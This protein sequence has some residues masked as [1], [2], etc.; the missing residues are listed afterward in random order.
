MFKF[1][2]FLIL[3]LVCVFALSVTA[4][5]SSSGDEKPSENIRVLPTV[6]SDADL[7][8]ITS[9]T[10]E[11]MDYSVTEG[12]FIPS[13]P[14]ADNL[15]ILC[16]D[17]YFVLTCPGVASGIVLTTN[18]GKLYS[19]RNDKLA[20][21]SW[22]LNGSESGFVVTDTFG[23]S[24][25]P[26]WTNRGVLEEPFATDGV[27][28]LK[29]D[30]TGYDWYYREADGICYFYH[31]FDKKAT[32]YICAWT[33]KGE[34]PDFD[35]P[36]LVFD[37]YAKYLSAYGYE[38]PVP[39][40]TEAATVASTEA[41]KETTV[42]AATTAAL[43]V[44]TTVQPT[45]SKSLPKSADAYYYQLDGSSEKDRVHVDVSSVTPLAKILVDEFVKV[46]VKIGDMKYVSEWSNEHLTLKT[47]DA[48]SS[49][50]LSLS[51]KAK[52]D[53]YLKNY[54]E[55]HLVGNTVFENVVVRT[56]NDTQ[57][58]VQNGE[59]YYKIVLDVPESIELINLA[60]RK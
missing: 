55:K 59:N 58:L 28:P 37:N 42:P 36:Q 1:K 22:T 48:S 47:E 29:S 12:L 27:T 26:I 43:P 53:A 56:A 50:T 45:E 49:I 32:E 15:G 8:V 9:L 38:K 19:L 44:E 57:L 4:C 39:A 30:V 10:T 52:H 17:T 34:L 35:N 21:K 23:M 25:C 54:S 60:L 41:P 6:K 20:F 7:D 33:I 18:E 24:N 40:P 16:G 3:V 2:N 46:G 13:S 11:P 14:S 5:S 51:D 31:F